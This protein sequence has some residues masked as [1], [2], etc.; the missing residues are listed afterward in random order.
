METSKN[1]ENR[2]F[3]PPHK[4]SVPTSILTKVSKDSRSFSPHLRNLDQEEV[5][6]AM[7]LR[8][9]K[10][11]RSN[12]QETKIQLHRLSKK[13]EEELEGSVCLPQNN[14]ANLLLEIV[15]IIIRCFFRH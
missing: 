2:P 15:E 5:H 7:L 4:V 14:V 10:Q 13:L 12:E 8:K 11:Q 9:Y 6:S 1:I 3:S